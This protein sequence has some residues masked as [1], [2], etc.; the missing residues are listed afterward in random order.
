MAQILAVEVAKIS[1]HIYINYISTITSG[2]KAYSQG[3]ALHE[4]QP[5]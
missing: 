2:H 5:F 3:V 1:I 4:S